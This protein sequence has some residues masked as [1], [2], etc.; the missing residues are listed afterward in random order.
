MRLMLPHALNSHDSGWVQL[1]AFFLSFCIQVDL[2][3]SKPEKAGILQMTH[4]TIVHS[5]EGTDLNKASRRRI[6]S[7]GTSLC[8]TWVA[9]IRCQTTEA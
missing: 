8:D 2:S 3:E 1:C 4:L 7:S 9:A 6:K 5:R